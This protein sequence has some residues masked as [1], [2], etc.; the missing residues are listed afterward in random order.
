MKLMDYQDMML[1]SLLWSI[2]H[3]P[4]TCYSLTFFL[5]LQLKSVLNGQ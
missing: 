1:P 2:C 5:F 3:I 4:Q